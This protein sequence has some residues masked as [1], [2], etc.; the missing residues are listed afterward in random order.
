MSYPVFDL[1]CDTAVE[2][3]RRDR[4]LV[5]ND[6]QIDLARAGKLRE[7]RQ[8]FSFCCV[9]GSA[10]AP[11]QEKEAE[12]LFQNSM[13]RFVSD[14]ERCEDRISLR[15]D[16]DSRTNH[17]AVALLSL[18]GPE[19]I[20][21]DPGRLE[22]LAG[23]G[24]CMTTLTWNYRNALA[25][26]CM[27]G[28][29]LTDRGRAFVREAQRLGIVLDVSHL[30]DQAFWELIELTQ[31]PLV[32]SHSNSRACCA[33]VRNLTDEQFRAIRDVG[34]LVG[35][36]LYVP[37]LRE[38]G[39]ATF[40]DVCRHLE[41]WLSLGGEKTVSLGGDLDGCDVLPERFVGVDD[42]NR[43]GDYLIEHGFGANLVT[44]LFFRNASRV[45]N[46]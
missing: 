34:G 32:A 6:L 18:E 39:Q 45:L 46:S 21:C 31:A 44:D 35:M 33:H 9:Y 42:Y 37:F 22:E 7:Y 24:F 41:H 15:P 17:G 26:S 28:E 16:K 40:D 3:Y 12:A 29:G 5:K 30:S 11:M 8:V 13:K 1:H 36:N 43:L 38:S 27:T 25:G 4:S 19:A 20:G 2:L 14:L 10:G 23:L